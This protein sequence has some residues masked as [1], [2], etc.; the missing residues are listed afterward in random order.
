VDVPAPCARHDRAVALRERLDHVV[1][2]GDV[3][4][5][6]AAVARLEGIGQ[7]RERRR[8]L[9]AEV[10]GAR[11]GVAA[12]VAVPRLDGAARRQRNEEQ[13]QQDSAECPHRGAS[14]P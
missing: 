13:E 12:P 7:L 8:I 1:E 6:D 3:E 14:F 4:G 9:H 11:P 10:L 2:E 5:E